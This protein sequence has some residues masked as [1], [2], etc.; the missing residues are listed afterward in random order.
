MPKPYSEGARGRTEGNATPRLAEVL[1]ISVD[2]IGGEAFE[3]ISLL[4][5]I[6]EE[7]PDVPASVLARC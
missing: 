3:R 4:I 6:R 5:Q 7:L 1:N 2:V